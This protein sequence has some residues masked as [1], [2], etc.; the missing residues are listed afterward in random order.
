MSLFTS[1]H[2]FL[3]HNVDSINA[4][5]STS[6]SMP[7]LMASMSITITKN[8]VNKSFKKLLFMKLTHLEM[9]VLR[10]S[11]TVT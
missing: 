4:I 6:H 5:T 7:P 2:N 1:K 9:G 8:T 3:N 10:V 11:E